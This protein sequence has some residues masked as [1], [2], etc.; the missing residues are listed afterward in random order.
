MRTL[1]AAMILFSVPAFAM[2]ETTRANLAMAEHRN[3]C[4][5]MGDIN[6][7]D[8]VCA[9]DKATM[10]GGGHINPMFHYKMCGPSYDKVMKFAL[11]HLAAYKKLTGKKAKITECGDEINDPVTDV[12]LLE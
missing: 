3:A 12:D 6:S 8:L 4:R 5:G 7:R 11:K 2:D 9:G 1:I 10:R